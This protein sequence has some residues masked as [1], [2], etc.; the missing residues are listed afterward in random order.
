MLPCAAMRRLPEPP[1]M[2][3]RALLLCLG[4]A[5]AASLFLW[6]TIVFYPFRLLVTLMHESGHA[7]MV[8]LVGGTVLSVTI[9]PS[10]GGLT[11]SMFEPTL[12][13]A[14]L[15]SSGGYLGSSIAGA[16][17]LVLAGRMRSG[18]LILWSLVAWMAVV[19][20]A[21][22]PLFPP[23]QG[24][25]VA[26]ASGYSRTDGLFTLAFIVGLGAAFGLVAWKAPVPVRRG[27]VVFIAALSCLES[28]RDIRNLFGYGFGP[29]YSDAHRM[30]E[31][32]WLPAP[33]WAALWLVISLVAMA[34]GVRSILKRRHGS[35]RKKPV[36]AVGL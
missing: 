28:L 23:E 22:V 9:S 24:D 14:T 17:L 32:T 16:G 35:R 15:V 5:A 30:A 10:Q 12:I 26:L 13:K 20:I 36:V 18:R 4:L 27:L 19:A 2:S 3:T 21:W 25:G 6:E 29:G 8:K 34:I 7:L 1:P 33:F 11:Y 31:L